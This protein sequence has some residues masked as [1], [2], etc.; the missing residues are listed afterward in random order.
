MEALQRLSISSS[1]VSGVLSDNGANIRAAISELDL[2]G[3]MEPID[4][5]EELTTTAIEIPAEFCALTC[6]CHTLELRV[7]GCS[8]ESLPNQGYVQG[9]LHGCLC[10]SQPRNSPRPVPTDHWILSN[11]TSQDKMVVLLFN[12]KIL[13]RTQECNHFFSCVNQESR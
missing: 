12:W 2:P 9:N 13:F 3:M 8:K 10:S 4:E 7:F 11:S 1:S 5:D 6:A